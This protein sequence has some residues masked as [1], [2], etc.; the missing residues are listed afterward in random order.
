[1][2]TGGIRRTSSEPG[3]ANSGDQIEAQNANF[4]WLPATVIAV[5]G[6]FYK[7]RFANHD[8]RHDES[9]SDDRIRPAGTTEKEAAAKTRQAE[10]FKL[11]LPGAPPS[12]AGAAP[13]LAGAAPSPPGTAWKIDFGRGLTGTVFQ[14]CRNRTWEIIPQRAGTIG[15]VGRS[16][17]VSGSTLTTVNAD[18]GMVEKWKMTWTGGVLELF[19]GETTLKLHYTGQNK[20]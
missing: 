14:F 2:A 1:M 18:D 19:D 11:T 5:E 16:Y 9:I 12:P 6:A 17:T 8:S 20:C 3:T 10:P 13:S 7:V 15:A 4:T